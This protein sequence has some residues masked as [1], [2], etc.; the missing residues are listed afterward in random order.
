MGGRQGVINGL[1]ARGY[2]GRQRPGEQVEDRKA[3]SAGWAVEDGG[4]G[5]L[6][7]QAVQDRNEGGKSGAKIC[8]AQSQGGGWEGE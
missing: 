8:A 7:G 5:R 6:F 3:A 2:R 1:S 4:N